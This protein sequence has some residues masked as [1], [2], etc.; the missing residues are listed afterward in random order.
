MTLKE[1]YQIQQKYR[2]WTNIANKLPLNNNQTILELGCGIGEFSEILSEKVH[3]VIAVDI[4]SEFLEILKNKNINNIN[5]IQN[6]IHDLVY[7]PEEI[8]GIFSSFTIAYFPNK[9]EVTLSN[10]VNKLKFNGW[11][12]I[13]EIDNLLRGHQPLSEKTTKYLAK[14]EKEIKNEGVY[15]FEAGRNIEPI[16]KKLGLEIILSENLDD[17]ELTSSGALPDNICSMWENRLN[18]LSFNKYFSKEEINSIKIEFLSLLK[19]TKHINETK[20]KFIIAKKNQSNDSVNIIKNAKEYV[21]NRLINEKTGHDWQHTLRVLENAKKIAIKEKENIDFTVVQLGALFHDVA[22]HKFGYSN[23]DRKNI[24]ESFLL[25]T[26]L[27][28]EQIEHVVYIANTTSFT[29]G[30]PLKTLES[31]IVQDADRLDALGAIGIARTFTFGGAFQREIYNPQ[32]MN[33]TISHFY[34]KLLKL[35]DLMNTEEGRIEAEKRD[36]FMRDFLK[37]FY[38]EVL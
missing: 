22:D 13:I 36:K 38:L 34:T 35:K 16:L 24:I 15:D 6:D 11:I 8:D 32:E 10:W 33:D 28:K 30:I 5:I 2:K 3:Q 17:S 4:N 19:N 9:M 12:A 31:K 14:F 20:V 26:S 1:E 27:T 23:I 37:Q 18:R 25:N 7:I 29:K 21:K